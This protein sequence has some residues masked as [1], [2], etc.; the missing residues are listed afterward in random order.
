VSA[1][2]EE[3]LAAFT[4]FTHPA[5]S[6]VDDLPAIFLAMLVRELPGPSALAFRATCREHQATVR[7]AA[8][9]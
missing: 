2:H 5:R 1:L 8:V 6:I 4:R 9:C 7:A 3:L